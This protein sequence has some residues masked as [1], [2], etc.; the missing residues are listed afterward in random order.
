MKNYSQWA[1]FVVIFQLYEREKLEV[2]RLR[3]ENEK[4]Q[5]EVQDKTYDL[6]KVKN[7]NESR[8]NDSRVSCC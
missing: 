7:K 2:E 5:Q 6:E 4:L 1:S 8:S 3:K